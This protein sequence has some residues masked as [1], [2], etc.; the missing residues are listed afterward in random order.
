ML[1]P[2]RVAPP[3]VLRAPLPKH[4]EPVQEAAGQPV[5]ALLPRLDVDEVAAV[6]ADE[7]HAEAVR[8]REARVRA[9]AADSL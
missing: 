9:L 6:E 8:V 4:L 1:A 2:P 5:L 7:D 3:Q